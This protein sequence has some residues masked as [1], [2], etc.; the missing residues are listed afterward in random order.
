LDA[1]RDRSS[2]GSVTLLNQHPRG[3]VAVL[4]SLLLAGACV[5]PDVELVASLPG[6]AG[7]GSGG[8]AGAAQAGTTS[9]A[10]EDSDEGGGDSGG[11][12]SSAGDASQGGN[13]NQGGDA[14]AV[15]A[16]GTAGASGSAGT[17]GSGGSA[18]TAIPELNACDDSLYFS[19][20]DFENGTQG[21]WLPGTPPAVSDD[22]PS[23]Q[24]ILTSD[25]QENRLQMQLGN[26]KVSFWV[27]LVSLADQ[28]VLSFFDGNQSMFGLGI[29]ESRLRWQY[30]DVAANNI[31]AV[32]PSD[33][34]KTRL[35]P[36]DEWFCLEVTVLPP[37]SLE[38]LVVIPGVAPYELPVLDG[39][40]TVGEDQV[41]NTTYPNWFINTNVALLFGQEGAYQEYDD[42]LVNAHDQPSLC[43]LYLMAIDAP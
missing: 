10:G 4:T 17:S 39:T 24:H 22:A 6:V 32:A 26:I 13:Q 41:W 40:A 5:V 18:P 11:S 12:S 25:Y 35:I 33:N 29:E 42:V 19:C 16:G 9:E 3:A 34:A 43:D 36:T 20:D 31:T 1:R 27:R 2:L 30:F 8:K 23:G 37:N 21:V 38:A 15:N 7:S 14:G 28:R